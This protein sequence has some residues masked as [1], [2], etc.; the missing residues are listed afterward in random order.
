MKNQEIHKI[1][2]LFLIATG[3]SITMY[4]GVAFD[5]LLHFQPQ[6]ARDAPKMADLVS[7][8]NYMHDLTCGFICMSHREFY[9]DALLL[10]GYLLLQPKACYFDGNSYAKKRKSYYVNR[11]FGVWW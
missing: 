11:V 7:R 3:R 1:I 2:L 6:G 10:H 8:C 4:L 5:W 9:Y